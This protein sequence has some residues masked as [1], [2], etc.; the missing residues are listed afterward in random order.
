MVL[1]HITKVKRQLVFWNHADMANL[2]HTLNYPAPLCNCF[3]LFDNICRVPVRLYMQDVIVIII[4]TGKILTSSYRNDRKRPA[5]LGR[6]DGSVL[7][8]SWELNTVLSEKAFHSLLC[9]Y[10]HE[11]C[12]QSI[13]Q[14]CF[15]VPPPHLDVSSHEE[16]A[17]CGNTAQ[18]A[19]QVRLLTKS[20]QT[21]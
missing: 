20:R 12:S 4:I 11:G 19:P 6:E 5:H 16:D 8:Y 2:S 18:T 15:L 21:T 10:C 1:S 3:P 14:C 9:P 13:I 17:F 7:L